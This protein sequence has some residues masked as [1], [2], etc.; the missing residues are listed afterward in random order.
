M[1]RIKPRHTTKTNRLTSIV[2]YAIVIF[3]QLM[4]AKPSKQNEI[5]SR[6]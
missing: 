5:V 3:R 2:P 4:K 6:K 1:Y